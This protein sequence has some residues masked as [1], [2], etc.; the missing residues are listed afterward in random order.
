[1]LAPKLSVTGP[2]SVGLRGEVVV[3]AV[4][5][6]G[7]AAEL[8]GRLLRYQSDRAADRVLAVQRALRSAQHLHALYVVEVEERALDARHVHVIEVDSDARIERLQCVR[9]ADAANVDVGAVRRTASLDEIHVRHG[10]LQTGEVL[11]LQH[12][13]FVGREGRHGDWHV[14][15]ALLAPARGDDHFL[16]RAGRGRRHDGRRLLRTRWVGAQQSDGCGQAAPHGAGDQLVH[17]SPCTTP[18]G[19]LISTTAEI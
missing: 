7:D 14:L 2:P 1:M 12:A 3:I 11:G 15:H 6:L 10:S 17:W 16:E 8:L 19:R 13:Q 9:L 5:E 18:I 4:A